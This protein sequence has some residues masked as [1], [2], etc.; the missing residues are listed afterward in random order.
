M[1]CV[2]VVLTKLVPR[3]T[4]LQRKIFLHMQSRNSGGKHTDGCSTTIFQH[5][6][7]GKAKHSIH[8]KNILVEVKKNAMNCCWPMRAVEP[9]R[10]VGAFSSVVLS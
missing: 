2:G 10:W 4:D 7:M 9:W 8:K 1:H 3:G 6:G 5:R